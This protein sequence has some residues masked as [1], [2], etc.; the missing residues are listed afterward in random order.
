LVIL[1]GH[2]LIAREREAATLATLLAHGISGK[3]LQTGKALALLSVVVVLLLPL[4]MI[5]GLAIR[6]GEHVLAA[7]GLVIAYLLYLSIWGALALLASALLT[8]RSVVL[9]T[10]ITLWIA[11][12][13]VLP[14]LAASSSARMVPIAGKLEADLSMLTELRKLGDS[15]NAND[16]AFAQLRAD[17]LAKHGVQRV[18]DLPFNL[19]GVVARFGEQ[20]LTDTLNRYAQ[21]QMAGE[22]QQA[23][24]LSLYGWLTPLVAVADASRA[25]SGTD[26]SHHHR[27]LRE[28]ES[29][30][31]A[32]V[33]GLNQIHAEKLS[34][35]DDIRR[36]IDPQAERRTRVDA[37]HWRLLQK[38]RFQPGSAE[39]R[40]KQAGDQWLMLSI[41][42]A[43]LVIS[44]YWVGARLKP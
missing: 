14:A 20:K 30:R 17:L 21:A 29:T 43:V 44:G 18:E 16:P 32:F 42:C 2:G 36:G 9:V 10:L 26:L 1:L 25:L 5:A 12:T 40:I 7:L 4:V 31:Y 13:L 37:A 33:Q 35:A 15:H 8:R 27:F 6:A 19:R 23:M 22:S 28:A 3:A 11:L 38:F 24:A 41:W 39:G 34:Y